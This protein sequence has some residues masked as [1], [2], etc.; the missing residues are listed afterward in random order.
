MGF[1]TRAPFT[2]GYGFPALFNIARLTDGMRIAA[3]AADPKSGSA[4][5]RSQA[6]DG[7][8]SP[9]VLMRSRSSLPRRHFGIE[10]PQ[11]E[12]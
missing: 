6:G 9:G 11:L 8:P 7:K 5:Y 12:H 10:P 3:A 2:S 4:A 1:S